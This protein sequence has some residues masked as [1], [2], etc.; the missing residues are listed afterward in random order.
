MKNVQ[1]FTHKLQEKTG[2]TV[3][4]M[5]NVSK[6]KH[7]KNAILN[8][9]GGKELNHK[10]IKIMAIVSAESYKSSKH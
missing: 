7:H 5:S 1:K 3:A 6:I 2:Q 8:P 10:T 4:K 9:I